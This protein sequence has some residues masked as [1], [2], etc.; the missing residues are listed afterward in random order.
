MGVLEPETE[1]RVEQYIDEHLPETL[2]ELSQYISIPSVS[3]GDGSGMAAAAEFLAERYREFGCQEVEIV[4]T[5]TYPGVWAYYDAGAPVTILN[6]NMYDVRSVGDSSAWQHEPFE[7]SVESR[8]DIPRVI[9]GRGAHVPKGPDTAWMAGLRALKATTG[10]LP[11]NIAFL[12]E[13]DEILGSISYTELIERYRDRLSKID[14]LI[15]LRAGEDANHTV[16][17]RL[18]YKSF[19]TIELTASGKTWGRGPVTAAHSALRTIV[20]SPSL[21]LVQ[22]ID[23][24]YTADGEIAVEPWLPHLGAPTVPDADRPLMDELLSRFEGQSWDEV[25]PAL[26]GTGTT[27]YAGDL[28]GPAVLEKYIYGSALNIQ[29]YHSG[30]VGPG[31]RTFTIPEKAT[32]RLDARLNT[33]AD[34]QVFIDGLRAHLDDKGFGDV[35]I[36]VLSAY[37]ASRTDVDSSLMR[38]FLDLLRQWGTD[39]VVWPAQAYG[40]P[41]S[42]LAQDFGMPL[43]FGAGIGFGGG[44]G[45]PDEYF[46]ID[47][48]GKVNGLPELARFAAEFVTAFAAA[49]EADPA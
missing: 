20:E 10:T 4:E 39:P 13:G 33:T 1:K 36:D 24:L 31:S 12:A 29:G 15:Y 43:V 21:R 38:T 2:A 49:R 8:G 41:W 32:V 28:T 44:V 35:T 18:G 19:I 37:P 30:Y 48:A 26:G 9:Y 11:V 46:V 6:Y 27:H 42:F 47:G 34:P 5:S 17:V 14:G 23:S 40:G 16:P 25:I 3:V 22:A 45:L 7:P